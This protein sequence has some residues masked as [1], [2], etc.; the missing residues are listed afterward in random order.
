[1]P[2]A[3]IV[4]WGAAVYR[5]GDEAAWIAY[6]RLNG[7]P[8]F[9]NYIMRS[10][11]DIGSLYLELL[12]ASLLIP[13]IP[14]P[15]RQDQKATGIPPVVAPMILYSGVCTAILVWWPGFNTRYAMPIAPS[16]AVL[17][18]IAWDRLE[19]SRYVIVRRTATTVLCLL[20]IYQFALA[21]VAVPLLS[22]RFG[23]TR[24]AGK[25]IE[26]AIL[27]APAP[28]YCLRLD[29]NIFFYV[30]VP[31]QC[32]DLQRMA[33]LTPPAWLLMPR[34]AVAEFAQLR[35][36]LDVRIVK[37]GLTEQ[38]LTATRIDKK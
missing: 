15:W 8:P 23:E 14:W 4:G 22:D 2:A 27:A 11:H 16:L 34:A 13:F 9:L 10:T 3:A 33:A 1:M 29:T 12:P 28:A 24:I 5:P 21:T 26:Q 25:S 31:L 18:A 7:W 30:H 32:L 38:Q 37:D 35:P 20:M 19:E 17:A 36:D 6:A